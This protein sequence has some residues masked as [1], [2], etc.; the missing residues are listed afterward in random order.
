MTILYIEPE[1]NILF[2]KYTLTLDMEFTEKLQKYIVHLVETFGQFSVY[3]DLKGLNITNLAN[4]QGWLEGLIANPNVNQ[5][6]DH[7][8][9]IK[10]Y[11]APLIA[12]Q[13]FSIISRLLKDIKGKIHFV[14]KVKDSAS[15]GSEKGVS[16]SQK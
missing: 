5:Y 16:L 10:I 14:P 4:Q 8:I 15:S 13:I 3:L 1:S 6:S 11:N 9:E 2:V 12:K 7:L